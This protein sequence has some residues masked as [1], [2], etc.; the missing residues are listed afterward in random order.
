MPPSTPRPVRA[1]IYTRLSRNRTGDRSD[2]TT[3]QEAE[4]RKL[5]EARGWQVV[6]V[7]VDDDLSA[8][9]GRRRPG[10]Q[11]LIDRA[12]AGLI[13][14]IVAWHPDRLHR[15]PVELE[16]FIDVVEATG[17]E[18]ATVQSGRVDLTTPS[19]RMHARQLGIIARYES[20]HRS[21]RTRLAHEALARDGK[22][23]GGPRPYGYQPVP[24]E[25]TMDVDPHEAE[26]V[27]EA[28]RRVLSGEKLHTITRDL[29]D[30]NEPTAR[31]TA[32]TPTTMR[33]IL[34]SPTTRGRRVSKGE[35][36]GPALWP[37]ILDDRTATRVRAVLT[38][39]PK[40]GRV[41]RVALL[42]AGRCTCGECGRPMTSARRTRKGDKATPGPRIYRCL[43]CSLHIAADP[44]EDLITEAIFYRLERSKIP[45][46]TKVTTGPSVADLEAQL[47]QLSTDHGEGLTTRAEWLA[48]REPLLRRLDD[49]RQREGLGGRTIA[50][51]LLGPGVARDRWPDLGLDQRQ[52]VF[53]VLADTVVVNRA[54]RRGPGLDP[55]RVHVKW[56]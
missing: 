56:R 50:T 41:A 22:W 30:R 37:A 46:P 28:A 53:D 17:I 25:G 44:L 18:V 38:A 32:W 35:D 23:K 45:K 24:G 40:R 27:A 16:A 15:R 55:D 9:S 11:S 19:G 49:A 3:R 8:Y 1:A 7:E 4:C 10:Y 12:E 20:E 21:E 31:G 33:S 39:P 52:A 5:A 42:T 13:D 43:R 51:E 2:S 47:V 54:T 29:N 26:V 48:Q 6:A 34:L 14:A 36:V